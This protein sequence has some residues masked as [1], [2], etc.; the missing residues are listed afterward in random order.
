MIIV[1]INLKQAL[2]IGRNPYFLLIRKKNIFLL[3]IR[4]DIAT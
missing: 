2:N 4:M 1:R 3:L